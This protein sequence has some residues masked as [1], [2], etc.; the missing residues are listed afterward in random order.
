[1]LL[2]SKEDRIVIRADYSPS[3]NK[4]MK[5]IPGSEYKGWEWRIPESSLW[6]AKADLELTE[7]HLF[8]YLK[9]YID[10]SVISGVT[11]HMVEETEEVIL[12]CPLQY[13]ETLIKN[14]SVLCGHEEV[15]DR[16]VKGKGRVFDTNYITLLK[17]ITQSQDT[18]KFKLPLGLAGRLGA[19]LNLFPGTKITYQPKRQAPKPILKFGALPSDIEVREYQ[20]AI[21]VAAARKRR[22][23]IVLPTGAGKTVT[24]GLIT[25]EL[26]VPTLF[27][28]YSKML[29]HQTHKSFAKLLGVKVGK[30]GDGEFD[31][32]EVTVSTVQTV[33]SIL[34]GMEGYEEIAAS[35]TAL[36]KNK[37]EGFDIPVTEEKTNTLIN[38]LSRVQCLF[39]DEGHM[40]GASTVYAAARLCKPHY[41]FAL[42]ATPHRM[43]NREIYIEAATGP[44]WRP[45][46]EEELIKQGYVLP[47]K[48]A[49]IP[50][51][52]PT[53]NTVSSRRDT[54]KLYARAITA[55]EARNKLIVQSAMLLAKKY[56]TVILIKEIAHGVALSEA[57][58]APF[59][60]ANTPAEEKE[61]VIQDFI[62]GKNNLII[63]S[64]ILET[65]VDIPS[66]DLIY[67]G[68]PRKSPIKILQSIGRARR[69]APGKTHALVV[70][71]C[72]IDKGVYERQSSRKLDILKQAN[73]EVVPWKAK[74][75]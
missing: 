54:A 36:Q 41:S 22:S 25:Q 57:T 46:S 14:I 69:P 12:K 26:K 51:K 20:V 42:T 63:S 75:V 71:I 61:T 3:F 37:S 21:Q 59:I 23:T 16:V 60:Y 65:G 35:I 33:L 68:T 73:F 34:S 44:V 19:F 28:T 31:I 17:E 40:L 38:Y 4:I 5:K 67:D 72:D 1:M 45:I 66:I 10:K 62:D 50:Y 30:V 53:P 39:V 48:V 2:F 6:Q 15:T 56:K 52:H 24:A 13:L 70:T 7:A 18:V 47:V 29:L 43:D 74:K 11:G 58:G 27:L 8:P 32:Q 64:P 55:N 49:V 9:D